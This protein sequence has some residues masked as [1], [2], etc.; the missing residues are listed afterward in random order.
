MA[1]L[2]NTPKPIRRLQEAVINRIA[3]G[4]IIHRPSSALKELLE[5]SLDAGAT[6]VRVTVKDGG[7][8]L[9]QIQDNGC[10]IHKD[11]LPILA[12]RFTTSKI[13]SFQDL[14]RLTTYGFRG[15]ALAS[16]SY[17]SHLSVVTKTKKDICA[18]RAIYVDGALA[19]PDGSPIDPKPCAGNDGTT[20]TVENLF[21]N[22]PTRLSA[23]RGSSEEY[24][25]ILD[26]VTK[27]AVHNPHVS[28]T[29]KKSG[30]SAPDLTTPSG[31]NTKQTIRLMYGP[32]IAKELIEVS[33][34][35]SSGEDSMDVDDDATAEGPWKAEV[36]CTGPNYE[37]KKM[38]F[39]LFIN[40]RLVESQRMK[41]AL[42]TIY[43]GIISKGSSPFVYLS[44]QIDPHSVDVNVHPTKRE[45]H[46]LDEELITR[47][48]CDT[49]I[50]VLL[51]RN[52]S[53][54]FEYQTLLTGGIAPVDPS[55]NKG[56][57]K[58][59]ARPEGE[60][61]V[62]ELVRPMAKKLASQHKVRTSQ[63][64]RTL[65]SMFPVV[66]LSQKGVDGQQPAPVKVSEIRSSACNLDS[67][68]QLRDQ[69]DRVKHAGLTEVLQN[70]VFVGIVDLGRCL[71]LIQH[72]KKL[73]LVN[74]GSLCEE[75]FYQLGV[76]QFGDFHR[77]TLDPPP[78]LQALVK[79]A[80]DAE[81]T[82][83]SKSSKS[84]ITDAIIQTIMDHREMLC[85]YFMLEI[86]E[87]GTITSI[88]HL[89]KGYTPNLDKLPLFLMRLGPQVKW[90]SEKACFRTFL[91]ELAYF[92]VPEPLLPSEVSDADKANEA[93]LRWQIQHV[94]F[95]AIAKHMQPPKS[96]LDRDVVQV[97]NLPELYRVFER[98]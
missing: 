38:V 87:T 83:K 59:R 56:K 15:E 86:S 28:F 65:D 8:K 71:A 92:Y 39:L 35:P 61:E 73:Y 67:V 10:G 53:R 91:R 51:R 88:P 85:E 60:D 2:S 95:P 66:N 64:D 75:F 26:V 3:A 74:Y 42:E 57:G 18:W 11:D 34:S 25:R 1:E 12:E 69:L 98:C 31:S 41:K 68:L 7:M 40:H 5:N 48:I 49:V 96:L 70:H 47:K 30:S 23:L 14:E 9:L 16:I 93:A 79:L 46:F 89:L 4:E 6:S 37:A 19:A 54:V 43:S 94:L 33:V 90:H 24:S 36:L 84:S 44:L 22:T 58:K 76:L 78:P 50:E 17:V 13:A 20:I 55:Q 97:A 62:S 32:T 52:T 63:Q 80:V 27:Y 77:I 72:A 82:S 45:V 29:C 21:Y 81:D